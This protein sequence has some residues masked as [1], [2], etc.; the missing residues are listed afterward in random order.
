[1]LQTYTR[2]G[3]KRTH[4]WDKHVSKELHKSA[5][6]GT[7][8]R[9]KNGKKEQ[10]MSKIRQHFRQ[11]HLQKNVFFHKHQERNISEYRQAA[12]A[13]DWR[14]TPTLHDLVFF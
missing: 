4:K 3:P 11:E 12:E 10:K 14:N 13:S 7:N 5:S 6:F 1:M 9:Q 2:I 8:N